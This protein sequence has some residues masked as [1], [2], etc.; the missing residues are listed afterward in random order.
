M[1]RK[2]PTRPHILHITVKGF[3]APSSKV[4]ALG[5]VQALKD[6]SAC[7]KHLLGAWGCFPP[8]DMAKRAATCWRPS[9][10]QQKGRKNYCILVEMPTFL[11]YD[12]L[13]LRVLY[14]QRLLIVRC[15]MHALGAR[16]FKH[17]SCLVCSRHRKSS[18][19]QFPGSKRLLTQI[20]S[21]KVIAVGSSK[22]FQTCTHFL[23]RHSCHS[24]RLNCTQ[25]E[26]RLSRKKRHFSCLVQAGSRD[27]F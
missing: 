27:V 17:Q 19:R 13:R 21:K 2:P 23:D 3:G 8:P 16:C 15:I 14:S 22:V 4:K 25:P 6:S 26:L 5:P 24:S 7:K 10:R 20:D 1:V 9:Y 11:L 12:A 18:V